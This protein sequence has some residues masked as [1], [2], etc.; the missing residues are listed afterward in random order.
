MTRPT[1]TSTRVVAPSR[2]SPRST[3]SFASS[4]L[5]PFLLLFCLALACFPSS[6]LSAPPLPP[7]FPIPSTSYDAEVALF[8]PLSSFSLS[9]RERFSLSSNLLRRD[10]H[11]SATPFIREYID[12]SALR[13]LTFNSSTPSPASCSAFSLSL[14][15]SA[16]L[17]FQ[18]TYS[19]LSLITQLPFSTWTYVNRSTSVRNVLADHWTV[20]NL[21]TTT[22][23]DRLLCNDDEGEFF[24]HAAPSSVV[25]SYAQLIDL[26]TSLTSLE[27]FVYNFTL[28]YAVQAEQLAG[29]DRSVPVRLTITGTRQRLTSGVAEAS[30]G[31]GLRQ[32]TVGELLPFTHTFDWLQVQP[33]NTADVLAPPCDGPD[34]GDYSPP[35]P[36]SIPPSGGSPSPH[37]A[38]PALPSSFTALVDSSSVFNHSVEQPTPPVVWSRLS[39]WVES[40]YW[41][42]ATG[43]G[44]VSATSLVYN[45]TLGGLVWNVSSPTC[46]VQR[47]RPSVDLVTALGRPRSLPQLFRPEK[48]PEKAAEKG[49]DSYRFHGVEEVHG[50]RCHRYDAEFK[51][52]VQEG[53]KLQDLYTFTSS[54]YF[55][56]PHWQSSPVRSAYLQPIRYRNEGVDSHYPNAPPPERDSDD[57]ERQ[58]NKTKADDDEDEEKSGRLSVKPK[59]DVK[60]HEQPPSCLPTLYH[61]MDT[62]DLYSFTPVVDP[63]SFDVVQEYG[64]TLSIPPEFPPR[65]PAYSSTV[66]VSS[67]LTC[68]TY[69]FTEYV[70]YFTGLYR[71]DGRY[72]GLDSVEVTNLRTGA[73]FLFDNPLDDEGAYGYASRVDYTD[74]AA[75]IEAALKASPTACSITAVNASLRASQFLSPS[76]DFYLSLYPTELWAHAD[77][78]LINGYPVDQWQVINQSTTAAGDL[79]FDTATFYFSQ[80][81]SLHDVQVPVRF[82]LSR[83]V[84]YVTQDSREEELE[85]TV[86]DF[87]QWTPVP[88]SDYHRFGATFSF[89]HPSDCHWESLD[90]RYAALFAALASSDGPVQYTELPT[91]AD[92]FSALLVTPLHEDS[93]ELFAVRW[94]V[95]DDLQRE[96]VDVAPLSSRSPLYAESH[97]S[98]LLQHEEDWGTYELLS[99]ASCESLDMSSLDSVNPLLLHY[100]GTLPDFFDGGFDDAVVYEVDVVDGVNGVCFTHSYKDHTN[101]YT[102]ASYTFNRRVCFAQDQWLQIPASTSRQPLSITDAG[103]RTTWDASANSAVTAPFTVTYEVYLFDGGVPS[104]A[105]FNLTAAGCTPSNITHV[106]PQSPTTGDVDVSHRY[107]GRVIVVLVLGVAFGLCVVVGLRCWWQQQRRRESALEEF[108]LQLSSTATSTDSPLSGDGSTL[109]KASMGIG[110]G[111]EGTQQGLDG[112]KRASSPRA[113]SLTPLI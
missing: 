96:R 103:T 78:D 65:P 104:A 83:V 10:G 50:V 49:S 11:Y 66:R 26:T 39:D 12:L 64:C 59:A 52:E 45:Y 33:L 86:V 105:L 111:A 92:S 13:V 28:H 97:R 70:D 6:S 30:R 3:R 8:F 108:I 17:F 88:F 9:F 79:L 62:W 48:G 27:A 15:H 5:S 7:P 73:S 54:V 36:L 37:S 100:T 38:R 71:V 57:G 19:L 51:Q 81:S 42:S 89:P 4:S 112:R 90:S 75:A 22:V 106:P 55:L 41:L 29:L 67:S 85:G 53:K 44:S 110:R 18:P 91:I 84:I 40:T 113:A 61:Y 77:T 20:T 2:I 69:G 1:S 46:S 32:K 43:N 107:R 101:P 58:K 102:N 87:V 80:P 23:D 98:L 21:S 76:Y 16:H 34:S 60:G 99:N 93:T 56:P 35:V 94:Y 109:T 24:C 82:E 68:Q 25:G 31:G 14:Q 63:S 47:W 72:H 95:D 74:R